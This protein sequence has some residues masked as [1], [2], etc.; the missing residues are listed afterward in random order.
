M[1]APCTLPPG[2]NCLVR[3]WYDV[4]HP[5]WIFEPR[6]LDRMLLDIAD[7]ATAWHES[8]PVARPGA[9]LTQLIC[10]Y[11]QEQHRICVEELP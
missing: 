2:K 6:V 4:D 9:A 3:C 7:C 8:M 5:D 10:R 1:L 11:L